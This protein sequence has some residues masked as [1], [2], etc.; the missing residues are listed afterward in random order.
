MG[1]NKT[2]III[3]TYLSK[4]ETPPLNI[5]EFIFKLKLEY[6]VV[7]VIIGENEESSID[8]SLCSDKYFT[9]PRSTKY[10]KL[11]RILD[12]TDVNYIIS[13]DSDITIN[14]ENLLKTI[15]N[16]VI[17]NADLAWGRIYIKSTNNNITTR[18]TRIDKFLS[19]NYIRPMLWKCNK[20]ITIPGQI[21]I[22][23]TITMRKA[24]SYSDTFLDDIAVGMYF[25][26]HYS[27][28]KLY[29]PNITLGHEEPLDSIKS[30]FK[31]RKRW[32][33]G[34][35]SMLRQSRKEGM[36]KYVII[37]GLSYHFTWLLN[38]FIMFILCRLNFVLLCSYLVLI[39]LFLSRFNYK[40]FLSSILY[41]LIFPVFH[42]CWILQ[43][44]RNLC[45][46][47]KI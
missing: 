23:K 19:H 21:F 35:V 3:A 44:V 34:Y 10:V 18:L 33:N 2:K 45:I 27:S 1:N 17:G 12:E 29:S 38:L 24:F 9:I 42:I 25:R 20:A 39:S 47:R 15:R 16:T 8:D 6:N 30:L 37:H 32:A 26:Q 5:E 11:K 46:K 14:I 4:L 41:I 31:Q 36:R 40:Y 22:M 13:I 7:Y 43:V 28:L